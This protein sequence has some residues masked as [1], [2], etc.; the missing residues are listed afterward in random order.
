[1]GQYS[2]ELSADVVITFAFLSYEFAPIRFRLVKRGN[3]CICQFVAKAT[4]HLT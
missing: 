3:N 2:F 1:M 4:L